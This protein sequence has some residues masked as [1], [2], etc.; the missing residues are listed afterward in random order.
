[1]TGTCPTLP[2]VERVVLLLEAHGRTA[3]LRSYSF[4]LDEERQVIFDLRSSDAYLF[5]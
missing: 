5:L 4:T 2:H 1:M 3:H